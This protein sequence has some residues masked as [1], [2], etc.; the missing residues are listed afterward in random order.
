MMHGQHGHKIYGLEKLYAEEMTMIYGRDFDIV[1]RV[2]RFHNIY[3]PHGTWRGML[4]IYYPFLFFGFY[5][6]SEISIY[7]C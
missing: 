2:A 6:L 4:H 5:P 7:F 1:T 3:G